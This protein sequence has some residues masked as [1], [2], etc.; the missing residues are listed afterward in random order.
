ML[1]NPTFDKLRMIGNSGSGRTVHLNGT[2]WVFHAEASIPQPERV[3]GGV[4]S[5]FGLHHGRTF[6]NLI[7]DLAGDVVCDLVR[8]LLRSPCPFLLPSNR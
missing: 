8:Y 1:G 4:G 7:A 6:L 5:F 2:G 3:R